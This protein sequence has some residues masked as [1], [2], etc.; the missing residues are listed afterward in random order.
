MQL[1]FS[2]KRLDSTVKQFMNYCSLLPT[3]NNFMT[4][5]VVTGIIE[6]QRIALTVH[7]RKTIFYIKSVNVLY[8]FYV[9]MHRK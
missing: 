2:A 1:V 8:L 3:C 5:D 7:S 6:L 4:T 9:K